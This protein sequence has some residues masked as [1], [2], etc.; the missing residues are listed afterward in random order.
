MRNFEQKHWL[1]ISGFLV[2]TATMLSGVQH[3]HEVTRPAMVAGLLGQLGVV[4]G[5]LF[6]GAPKSDQ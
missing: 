1:L 5:S 2:A 6:A 3:W 4:I